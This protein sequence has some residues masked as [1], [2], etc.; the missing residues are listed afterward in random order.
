MNKLTIKEINSYL[1]EHNPKVLVK[2]DAFDSYT[3]DLASVVFR[4]GVSQFAKDVFF[5][6]EN[7]YVN[8]TFYTKEATGWNDGHENADYDDIECVKIEHDCWLT[9]VKTEQKIISR[10]DLDA[11]NKASGDLDAIN[12]IVKVA[13]KK[14]VA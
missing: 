4:N 12:N 3:I 13:D 10:S 14:E 6:Y 8:N 1:N 9:E 7:T 2:S 11:I 5:A